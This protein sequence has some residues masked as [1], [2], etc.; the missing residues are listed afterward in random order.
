MPNPP[1][2]TEV[3]V[4]LDVGGTEIKGAI[5]GAEGTVLDS[6][7]RPTQRDRG[8]AAVVDR[9]SVFAQDLCRRAT[10]H[11]CV[12]VAAGIA[13]P[14][15]VD[16]REGVARWSSNL[17]WRDVPFQALLKERLGMP[18]VIGQDVR[19]GALAEGVLGAASGY[20]DY[21]FMTIGT[22]IGG[23]LVLDGRPYAGAHAS[24]A[25]IGHI[26][27]DPGGLLCTCGGRGCLETVASASAL[28]S[29][30]ANACEDIA[31][32][33]DATVVLER[34]RAGDPTASG[35]WFSAVEAMSA[36]LATTVTLLDPAL[37]VIGGGLAA[38]GDTL[39]GPLSKALAARLS[40]QLMPRLLQAKLG[41]Q[42]GCLGAALLAW[43]AALRA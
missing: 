18:V 42:A 32:E 31:S 28:A 20:R 40:F 12:V 22:G 41:T 21:F 1:P 13:V 35:V 38:A 37:V 7:R 27:V 8:P 14:G 3:V 34:V 30:Y 26:V 24:A 19:A 17:G 4:G 11:G 16:E 33:M 9:I 2:G 15:Q 10:Q 36:A 39:F 29:R 23:A 43:Q 5:T 25:E 6:D